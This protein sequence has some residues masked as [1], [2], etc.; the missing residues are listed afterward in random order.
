MLGNGR[1]CF[2]ATAAAII[3]TTAGAGAHVFFFFSF[4]MVFLGVFGLFKYSSIKVGSEGKGMQTKERN[5]QDGTGKLEDS[6]R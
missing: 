4:L 5:G 1:C 3:I 2:D 6:Q